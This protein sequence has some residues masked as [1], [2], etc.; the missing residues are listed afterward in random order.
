[1][2]ICADL[3]SVTFPA[4]LAG[5]MSD[6]DILFIISG[7]SLYNLATN[8]VIRNFPKLRNG[9]D[10]FPEPILFDIIHQIFLR[11]SN[12]KYRNERVKR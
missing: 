11:N 3:K 12:P 10:G 5:T 9:L 7:E 4:L 6:V 8:A 2:S 1:M